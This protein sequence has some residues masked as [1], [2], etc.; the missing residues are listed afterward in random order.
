MPLYCSDGV[1]TRSFDDEVDL[2]S[3]RDFSENSREFVF[4]GLSSTVSLPL[5]GNSVRY[6]QRTRAINAIVI[7]AD[8]LGFCWQTRSPSAL[9]NEIHVTCLRLGLIF[10]IAANEIDSYPGSR[11][12]ALRGRFAG[13]RNVSKRASERASGVATEGSTLEETLEVLADT[14]PRYANWLHSS[15]LPKPVN[16]VL[17]VGAGTGTMTLLFAQD[18]QVVAVEPSSQAVTA[19]RHNVGNLDNVVVLESLEQ[20]EEGRNFDRIV[21]VNVLEHVLDDVSLLKALR[22]WLAPEGQVLVLSPAHNCLYST[23]DASIGHVRR[24]T[25]KSLEATMSLAGYPNVS[26]RYFNSVG[27]LAWLAVNRLL[28]TTDASDTTTRFYDYF[29]VPI[30]KLIDNLR[31]RPFGQSVI[32]VA[33]D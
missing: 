26:C 17:E 8:V 7:P 4:L 3:L 5:D 24:Y 20:L 9:L 1:H 12:A 15:L 29:I 27:A 16:T 19:L 28:G 6:N 23:F 25:R 32:G 31:V 13:W 2:R 18:A 22:K 30:S 11:I 21:L 14:M 10:T 33:S